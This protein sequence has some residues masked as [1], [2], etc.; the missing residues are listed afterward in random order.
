MAEVDNDNER[1]LELLLSISREEG[2]K[3][4]EKGKEEKEEKEEE[5]PEAICALWDIASTSPSGAYFMWQCK[6]APLLMGA[7]L[8]SAGYS[9]EVCLGAVRAIISSLVSS[10]EE[11]QCKAGRDLCRTRELAE[12]CRLIALSDADTPT[13]CEVCRIALHC[14]AAAEGSRSLWVD[15]FR[16]EKVLRKIVFWIQ[17]TYDTQL[18]V[19]A[20]ELAYALSFYDSSEDVEGEGSR[21]SAA[22]ALY[23]AGLCGTAVG[24]LEENLARLDP[25]SKAVGPLLSFLLLIAESGLAECVS[26]KACDVLEKIR[27]II[28]GDP[29]FEEDEK[30]LNDLLAI[31]SEKG[32]EQKQK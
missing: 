2:K 30:V 26:D 29:E 9:R 25:I 19:C 32:D 16:G 18:I 10:G 5:N 13:L 31:V 6:A 22:K 14:L 23:D 28:H 20:S 11:A 12:L 3:G 4:D 8:N 17:N 15:V 27:K 24:V 7:A 21:K 1:I